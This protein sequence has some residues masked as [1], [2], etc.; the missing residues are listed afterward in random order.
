[1]VADDR[2]TTGERQTTH[3]TC[4]TAPHPGSTPYH[5]QTPPDCVTQPPLALLPVQS[6]HH[7]A[8]HSKRVHGKTPA[9][10][11]THNPAPARGYTQ[12]G[13]VVQPCAVCTH[14]SSKPTCRAPA[15]WRLVRHSGALRR[16]RAPP[17]Q[18]VTRMDGPH[19]CHGVLRA[20]LGASVYISVYISVFVC[21]TLVCLFV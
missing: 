14:T 5:T 15:A 10:G 4:A 17:E 7:T 13:T 11:A 2:Y 18:A 3:M 6:T 21:L 1:L 20:N 19:P 9:R 16:R 12:P 8:P